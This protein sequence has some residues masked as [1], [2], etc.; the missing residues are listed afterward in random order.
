MPP[1]LAYQHGI[2]PR[3]ETLVAATRDLERDRT[4]PEKVEEQLTREREDLVDL[5]REAGLD[6]ISDGLL[7]WQDLF[8]PLVEGSDDLDARVLVRWFDNNSFFRAPA[9]GERPRLRSLPSWVT[10]DPPPAWAATLPSPYLFSR[11]VQGGGERDALMQALARDVLAPAA[12]GLVE[13]GARLIHL[14]EPWMASFGI[15]PASWEPFEASVGLIREATGDADV[16]LH[17][18]FGDAAPLAER[19][20]RLPVDAVGIDF[21]ETPLESLSRPWDTGLLVGAIDGRRSVVEDVDGTVAFVLRAA[22]TLSPSRL[23]VSSGSDLELLPA[24]VARQKIRLLSRV[25]GRLRAEER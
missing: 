7:R 20:R 12:R 6:L 23:L 11:A 15:D 21:V 18:Y 17:T 3:S 8:R 13:A 19:L 22:E 24:Q 9:V 1:V 2:F 5:Q 10:D 4:T 14:Q 16:V 25:A